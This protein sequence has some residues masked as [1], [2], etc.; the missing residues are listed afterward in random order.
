MLERR[1]GAGALCEPVD[2]RLDDEVVAGQALDGVDPERD[3]DL[4]P[5]HGQLGVMELPFG[6]Q[7]DPGGEAE[8]IP[9][10]AEGELPA[11]PTGAISLPALIQVYGQCLGLVLAQRRGAFRVLDGML[12]M[13]RP[14]LGQSVAP[15][16]LAQ[17]P[18]P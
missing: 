7:R 13:Q 4:P 3:E 18:E 2:L 10:V 6:E 5:G 14:C 12:L 15:W 1:P 17:V 11:E 16:R 8:G 9:E